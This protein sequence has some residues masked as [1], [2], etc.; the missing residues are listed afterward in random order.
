M[1]A[2]A[3]PTSTW[4]V[5]ARQIPTN[6]EIGGVGESLLEYKVGFHHE[7]RDALIDRMR[8]SQIVGIGEP[9]SV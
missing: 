6:S 7:Y 8:A 9:E 5:E 4:V 1:C 3:A 2:V